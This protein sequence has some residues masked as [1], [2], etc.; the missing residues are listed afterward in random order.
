MVT[1]MVTYGDVPL[2]DYWSYANRQWVVGSGDVTGIT[3]GTCGSC[4]DVYGC[5]DQ[6]ACN[7]DSSAN[8]MD[9]SAC[10]Y[11]AAGECDCS[12][13]LP[14]TGYDCD[15]NCVNDTDGDGVCDEFADKQLY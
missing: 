15:G 3:Y 7:F 11:I 10:V 13:N 4:D 12:G 5:M 1:D 8:V 6:S 9:Y 2:T 14:N